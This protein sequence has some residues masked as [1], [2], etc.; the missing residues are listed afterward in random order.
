MPAKRRARVARGGAEFRIIAGLTRDLPAGRDVVVGPGDDAAVVRPAP[1]FDLVLT[2]DAFLEERHWRSRWFGASSLARRMPAAVGSRLVAANLSDIAAMGARARWALLAAGIEKRGAS[3]LA[4]VERSAAHALARE[5]A[6]LTG[7]NLTRTRGASWLIL[8]L[9]GEVEPGRAWTRRGA[10]PGD[11]IAVT[12]TPGLAGAFV[13]LADS[14]RPGGGLRG[15]RDAIAE[16]WMN[17]PSRIAAARAL[18]ATGGVTAAIDISDGLAGDLAHLCRSSGVGADL[19]SAALEF[20]GALEAA[21]ARLLPRGG[22]AATRA[23]LARELALGP[24][25]DYEL[26]LA[27]DAK[28][29]EACSAAAQAAGAPLTFIGTVTARAGELALRPPDGSRAPLGGRGYDHFAARS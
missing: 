23:R 6:A 24:S 1:G 7:G 22:S 29:R 2:T 28:L 10:K 21:A 17:P 18:A 26:L 14:R 20:G 25:D 11:L 13:R 19:D 8:T 9:I 4:K 15:A 3:W 12:G 27:V 5:G 16:G